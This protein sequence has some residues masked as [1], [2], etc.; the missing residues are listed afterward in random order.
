M[1]SLRWRAGASAGRARALLAVQQVGGA[2]D[3]NNSDVGTY[4]RCRVLSCWC[5]CALTIIA[6]GG[7][8]LAGMVTIA[9][10]ETGRLVIAGNDTRLGYDANGS[11]RRN[12]TITSESRIH[13]MSLMDAHPVWGGLHLRWVGYLE[14]HDVHSQLPWEVKIVQSGSAAAGFTAEVYSMHFYDAAVTHLFFYDLPEVILFDA[15]VIKRRSGAGGEYD[16]IGM[17][18][19]STDRYLYNG[20]RLW[21]DDSG[22]A[23]TLSGSDPANGIFLQHRGGCR[24]VKPHLTRNLV[25]A[26]RDG[27]NGPDNPLCGWIFRGGFEWAVTTDFGGYYA[28]MLVVRPQRATP[29]AGDRARAQVLWFQGGPGN[30]ESLDKAFALEEAFRHPMRIERAR[31]RSRIG[32]CARKTTGRRRP[33]EIVT[34]GPEWRAIVTRWPVFRGPSVLLL[35]RDIRA[36]QHVLV[37]YLPSPHAR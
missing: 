23:G 12:A 13:G 34:L 2:H 27:S 25:I 16:A 4:S 21:N 15:E 29:D 7:I 33:W 20:L 31:E 32:I 14:G 11:P 36:H 10:R 19:F 26:Q 24:Y 28:H 1:F 8:A 30:L 18:A 6:A 35:L 37:G 3:W 22:P 5:C 17:C 9:Q